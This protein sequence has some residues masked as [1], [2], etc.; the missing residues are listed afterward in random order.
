MDYLEEQKKR[1]KQKKM[2]NL[3]FQIDLVSFLLKGKLLIIQKKLN[4]NEL[5]QT[6]GPNII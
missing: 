1:K 6:K 4:C 5:H 2:K 3:N